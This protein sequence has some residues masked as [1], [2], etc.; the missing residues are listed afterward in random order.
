MLKNIFLFLSSIIFGLLIF[1]GY[2]TWNSN[3]TSITIEKLNPTKSQFSLNKAPS[4]TLSANISSFSGTVNWE[5][6]T[7]TQSSKLLTTQKIQQGET[8]TT[9]KD[10]KITIE[11][12]NLITITVF[13]NT[14]LNFIQTIPTN[15]VISQESGDA[16]YTNNT[17]FTIRINN[18][19]IK[20]TNA[21]IDTSIDN[22]IT[23]ISVLKGSIKTAYNNQE[24][25]SKTLLINSNQQLTFDNNN[26]EASTK[27]I[28]Q[29]D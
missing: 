11:F 1:Y 21:T 15:I 13:P 26:K 29:K 28:P 17:P 22:E 7:A 14:K 9:E 24:N 18:L 4:D 20:P 8:I 16:E 23:T 3:P 5:S 10:G 12:P 27:T 6:R 19:L 2:K 25:I